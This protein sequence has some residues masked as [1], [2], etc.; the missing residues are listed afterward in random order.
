MCRA[1]VCAQRSADRYNRAANQLERRGMRGKD[2][3]TN[4][5][6]VKRRGRKNVQPQTLKP[7]DEAATQSNIYCVCRERERERE[8]SPIPESLIETRHFCRGAEAS[9][10]TENVWFSG[11]R[12]TL[13]GRETPHGA[14]MFRKKM[15]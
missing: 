9:L 10:E 3:S 14:P 5:E 11:V 13:R 2:E 6:N 15:Q 12:A 7:E 4:Q 1:Y 8:P